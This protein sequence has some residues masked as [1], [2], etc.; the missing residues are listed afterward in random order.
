MKRAENNAK[1]QGFRRVYQKFLLQT[2]YLNIRDELNYNV[3]NFLICFSKETL[4]FVS[5]TLALY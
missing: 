4:I 5:A 2:K 3:I 1:G